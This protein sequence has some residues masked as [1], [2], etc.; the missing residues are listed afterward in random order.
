MPVFVFAG[1]VFTS[2]LVEEIAGFEELTRIEGAELIFAGSVIFIDDNS[3]L[4][5]GLLLQ[6]I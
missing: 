4:V 3:D 5:A 1:M 6:P 2:G